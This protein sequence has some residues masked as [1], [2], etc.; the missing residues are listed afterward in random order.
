MVVL[1]DRSHFVISVFPVPGWSDRKKSPLKPQSSDPLSQRPDVT[2]GI[3][4]HHTSY[5]KLAWRAPNMMGL[6]K[7][8]LL[9]NMA[10]F[11]LYV[12]SM[13]DYVEGVTL[14]VDFG[15]THCLFQK[16]IGMI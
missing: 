5:R 4:F 1:T 6:G 7:G 10:I 16:I 2:S 15:K 3:I 12:L 11:G 8:D 9:E 14:N 13:L